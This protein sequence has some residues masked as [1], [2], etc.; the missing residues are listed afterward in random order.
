MVTS[1]TVIELAL[2]DQEYIEVHLTATFNPGLV[3][4]VLESPESTATEAR[5]LERDR[6]GLSN[7]MHESQWARRKAELA[8]ELNTRKITQRVVTQH[9]RGY[10][11]K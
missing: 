6:R 4:Q 7:L 1:G 9:G 3:E 10:Q 8:R 11:W 2:T 5:I